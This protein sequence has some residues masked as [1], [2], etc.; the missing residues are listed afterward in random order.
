MIINKLNI[1]GFLFICFPFIYV[2]YF[3]ISEE[4]I[5]MRTLPTS[6]ASILLGV[7]LIALQYSREMIQK[8]VENEN[9]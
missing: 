2:F 7:F 6:C 3:L 5:N 8:K 9:N 4:T 1:F